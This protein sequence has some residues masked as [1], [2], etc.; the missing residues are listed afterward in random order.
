MRLN[1]KEIEDH[2]A[3]FVHDLAY[4]SNK[5]EINEILCR[6]VGDIQDNMDVEND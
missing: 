5:D 3:S 2:V 6:L 4:T 1:D